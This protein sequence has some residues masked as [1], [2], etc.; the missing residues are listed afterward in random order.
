[1][2]STTPACLAPA[3]PAPASSG[4]DAPTPHQPGGEA[5]EQPAVQHW[6]VCRGPLPHTPS[7][8]EEDAR[9]SAARVG[10]RAATA[11]SRTRFAPTRFARGLRAIAGP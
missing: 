3:P 6:F 2:P 10:N 9:R 4:F 11:T 1:V 8:T 5:G 7:R